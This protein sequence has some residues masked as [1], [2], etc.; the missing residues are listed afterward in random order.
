MIII[1]DPGKKPRGVIAP[2]CSPLCT[3]LF[4]KWSNLVCFL[5]QYY[6][7]FFPLNNLSIS[8]HINCIVQIRNVIDHS[9]IGFRYLPINKVAI[10]LFTKNLQNTTNNHNT[11]IQQWI[12]SIQVTWE[13]YF[14]V[15][16]LFGT[17]IFYIIKRSGVSV[18][19]KSYG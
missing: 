8:M 17:S 12:V 18:D 13:L 7:L 15:H 4:I 2:T 1:I 3:P 6:W 5:P 19:E 9:I 10:K 11:T 16:V 14:E